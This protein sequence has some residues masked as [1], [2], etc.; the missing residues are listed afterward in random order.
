M[1]D[2]SAEVVI[3][4][5]GPVGLTLAV[6]LRLHGVRALVLERPAPPSQP[7]RRPPPE[8]VI[9]PSKCIQFS[10]A[11]LLNPVAKLHTV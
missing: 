7:S 8:G 1:N 9:A 2:M 5:A 6:E 4:G 11:G 3:V 10:G